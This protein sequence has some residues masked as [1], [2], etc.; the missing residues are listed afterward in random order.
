MIPVALNTVYQAPSN[1]AVPVPLNVENYV[2]PNTPVITA[3]PSAIL[4][5]LVLLNHGVGLAI[6]RNVST[7]L[8]NLAG[9]INNRIFQRRPNVDGM[10]NFSNKIHKV[11]YN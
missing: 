9:F 1:T 8:G 4:P 6:V 2:P 11:L 10:L 3:I 7:G 5:P